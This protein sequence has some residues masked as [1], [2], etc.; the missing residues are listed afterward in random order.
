M[1]VQNDFFSV[2]KAA[3]AYSPYG[4]TCTLTAPLNVK[5][6]S[7]V[8]CIVWAAI[9][10][11]WLNIFY[12]INFTKCIQIFSSHEAVRSSLLSFHHYGK[13]IYGLNASITGTGSSHLILSEAVC[14]LIVDL[15]AHA[16]KHSLVSFWFDNSPLRKDNHVLWRKE[17]ITTSQVVSPSSYFKLELLSCALGLFINS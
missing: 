1:I 11:T 15:S 16:T 2:L 12:P 6:S 17:T 5:S 14:L 4:L 7:K 10:D 9:A 13:S 3:V 8:E